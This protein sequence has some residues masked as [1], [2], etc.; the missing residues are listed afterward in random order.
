MLTLPFRCAIV[1]MAA[2]C[3]GCTGE[4]MY[5]AYP[6]RAAAIRHDAVGRGWIPAW[7]P[8]SAIDLREAH[9]LD[10]NE[11][12]LGF[13]TGTER[14]LLPGHCRLVAADV[15]IPSGL[16]LHPWPSLEVLLASY[17]IRRCDEPASA[18]ESFRAIPRKGGRVLF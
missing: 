18:T 17:R 7:I 6:D 1:L 12:A 14:W 15:V 4:V 2:F 13:E 3:A 16:E 11:S 10:T 5:A 8:A 9:D